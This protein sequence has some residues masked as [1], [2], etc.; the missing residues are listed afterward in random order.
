MQD[1]KTNVVMRSV[2]K[3]ALGKTTLGMPIFITTL[4]K[5]REVPRPPMA[6]PGDVL[7]ISGCALG[8]LFTEPCSGGNSY[9]LLISWRWTDQCVKPDSHQQYMLDERVGSTM[10]WM[11]RKISISG[12]W[13]KKGLK[14]IKLR[15]T[16]QWMNEIFEPYDGVYGEARWLAGRLQPRRAPAALRHLNPHVVQL[17]I[18]L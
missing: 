8:G 12:L 4:G 13:N 16:R 1:Y 5:L 2:G 11:D 7:H 10:R 15:L 6:A 3:T 9:W 14:F 18:K 17:W